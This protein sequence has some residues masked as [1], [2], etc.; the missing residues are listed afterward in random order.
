M[1]YF[2]TIKMPKILEMLKNNGDANEFCDTIN[3]ELNVKAGLRLKFR[4]TEA[5][6]KGACHQC[7]QKV[8]RNFF[9][10]KSV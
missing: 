3:S 7:K 4:P 6:E 2:F 8:R 9:V 5:I 10:L 1:Q